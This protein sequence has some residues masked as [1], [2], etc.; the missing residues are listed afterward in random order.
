LPE[1]RSCLLQSPSGL[2]GTLNRVSVW[3]PAT[4]KIGGVHRS[5][6]SGPA[7]AGEVDCLE[8]EVAALTSVD[9]LRDKAVMA[10]L[11]DAGLRKGE[12]RHLRS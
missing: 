9:E 1:P 10:V 2:L 6:F 5:P 4:S 3:L 11:I 12:A 7:C 8:A